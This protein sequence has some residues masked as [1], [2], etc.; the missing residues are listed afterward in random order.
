MFNLC[1]YLA[2]EQKVVICNQK[3]KYPQTDFNESCK[4]ER[5]SGSKHVASLTKRKP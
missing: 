1:S 3:Q 2:M 5:A 4:F